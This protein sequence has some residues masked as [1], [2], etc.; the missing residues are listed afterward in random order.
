M[1]VNAPHTKSL[2][3]LKE[4]RTAAGLTQTQLAI[5]AG[6]SPT[7]VANWEQQRATPF[8]DQLRRLCAVLGVPVDRIGLTPYE[9]LLHTHDVWYHL[10]AQH[11]HDDNSW[12]GRC[13]GVDFSERSLADP[14]NPYSNGILSEPMDASDPDTTSVVVPVTWKWEETGT[15]PEEAIER[16]AKRITTAL[17][18][19]YANV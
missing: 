2:P 5:K 7:T 18:R 1:I 15:T 4:L 17:N 9:Y 12:I 3:T 19:C 8:L 14:A 16:L 10:K 11:T 13:L 6:V